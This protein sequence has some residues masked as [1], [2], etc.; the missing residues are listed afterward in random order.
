MYRHLLC[1]LIVAAVPCLAQPEVGTRWNGST[2]TPSSIGNDCTIAGTW[3]GGS[4]VAYQLTITPSIPVGHFIIAAEPM[5]VNPQAPLATK[6]TGQLVKRANVYEGSMLSLS[7]DKSFIDLPPA[8]NPKMPDL[9]VGW[10]S[11]KLVDCN[12]IQNTIPF[13]GLYFGAGIWQPGTPWTGV[14][15]AAS[16]KVPLSDAPDVD[17]IPVLTGGV[18]PILETYH[19]L[20]TKINP[21]L[22][23]H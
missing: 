7:G 1:L 10:I 20:A 17:L 12:T 23:H 4:A 11:M 18:K 14:Q 9:Q 21:N 16:G 19:R 3:Y 6:F 2:L 15:W 5:Y 8:T 13:F 22:L